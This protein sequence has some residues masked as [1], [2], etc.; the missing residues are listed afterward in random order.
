M[1]RRLVVST[2]LIVLVVLAALAVPV[3]IVV[4][5]AAESE[6]R[7]RLDDVA[8]TVANSFADDLLEGRRPSGSRIDA[9]LPPDDGLRIYAADGRELVD[10]VPGDIDNPVVVMRD[11]PGGTQIHVIADGSSLDSRFREQVYILLFL[12]VGAVLA[13]A[14]LAA[15]QARQLAR[16]LER[17]SGSASRLG[18]GDFSATKLPSTGIPEIDD[19][20]SALRVSGARLSDMLSAERHFTADATHQLR[21][22]LTGIAMRFELLARDDDPAV[23]AEATA[24]LA[25]TEQMNETIDELLAL[26]R[27]G[28]VRERGEFDLVELIDTHVAEWTPRFTAARRTLAVVTAKQ[29]SVIGTRG[30][31]GQVIDILI[32]NALRHGRGSVTLLVDGP[33][34]VVIDQGPGISDDQA[35][36]VF[37]IPVDP[38]APHGRGLSLA[39]RLAEVD[40][41]SVEIVEA[42]PL[43]V[44]YRLVRA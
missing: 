31:A 1:R 39:R 30:L 4:Y 38:A 22:G 16:P 9:I 10:R 11:G 15:V 40:G 37:D 24:G 41:G 13:A 26:A 27:D 8:T 29:T 44:R 2:I 34:V 42:R 23:V 32:D 25:Q 43:R 36:T 7:G 33:S 17:L 14:A 19:I 35:R 12:V 3:G 6:L 5:R 28:T 18:V 21:T 20:S